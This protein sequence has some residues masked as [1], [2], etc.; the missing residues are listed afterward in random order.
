VSPKQRAGRRLLA[1]LMAGHGF[2]P[3]F[4]EWWHFTLKD[5][6]FPDLYFDFPVR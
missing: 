3:F 4:M 2:E 1:D 6:P 5:E